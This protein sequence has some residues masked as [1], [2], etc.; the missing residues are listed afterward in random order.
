MSSCSPSPADGSPGRGRR[1]NAALHAPRADYVQ[2]VK[3]CPL[4]TVAALLAGVA[5]C[6]GATGTQRP[7]TP[8]H[9]EP[10][11]VL[12]DG[13]YFGQISASGITEKSFHFVLSCLLHSG[14]LKNMRGQTLTLPLKATALFNVYY[15]TNGDFAL[16][17]GQTADFSQ[18]SD[19]AQ[20]PDGRPERLNA[21]FVTITDGVVT[22]VVEKS[23][24]GTGFPRDDDPCFVFPSPQ[25][26]G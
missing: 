7:P 16:G 20:H 21:W 23:P 24:I 18:W 19:V 5:G 9:M 15:A 14:A 11:H 4:L 8:S 2:S 6:G 22:D 17:H 25:P 3:P 13:G 12:P 1:G 26:S 10:A